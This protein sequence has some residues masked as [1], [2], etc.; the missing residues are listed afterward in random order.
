[1]AVKK[2]FIGGEK[3]RSIRRK[4]KTFLVLD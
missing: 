2:S 1:V 3:K 4:S